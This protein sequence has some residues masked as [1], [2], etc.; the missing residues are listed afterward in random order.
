MPDKTEKRII[1]FRFYHNFKK[2]P[3]ITKCI[4]LESNGD[5]A[6]GLAIYNESDPDSFN[7]KRGKKIALGRAFKALKNRSSCS[8]ILRPEVTEKLTACWIREYFKCKFT[9]ALPIPV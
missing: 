2:Q 1:Q 8:D 7:G 4:I 6:T 5:M 9:P 3:I